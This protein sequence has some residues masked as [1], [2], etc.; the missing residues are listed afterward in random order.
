MKTTFYCITAQF[1]EYGKVLACITNSREATKKPKEQIR[2]N[3][4]MTAYK[5][6]VSHE[7]DALEIIKMILS[8]DICAN[9]M[10]ILFNECFSLE[11]KAA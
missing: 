7:M 9:D 6:W 4:G 3:Y 1:Y 8:G 2:K 5:I 10:S 11:E